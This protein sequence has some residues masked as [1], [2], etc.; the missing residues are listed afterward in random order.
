[1]PISGNVVVTVSCRLFMLL[2]DVWE[3]RVEFRILGPLEVVADGRSLP[4]GGAKQRAVLAM[5][6][7][8]AGRVASRDR[9]IEGLWQGRPPD[10]AEVTLRGY[11]SRLR[12]VLEPN[13]S[14]KAASGRHPSRREQHKHPT[15]TTTL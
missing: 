4:L 8:Q 1:M 9:L 14:R 11:V 12:G 10:H 15:T 3:G 5:L 13:R 7:V 2:G 6:V